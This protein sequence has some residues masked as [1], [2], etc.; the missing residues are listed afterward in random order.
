M[1]YYLRGELALASVNTAV[2]DCGG[3]GY[4]L[5][6]SLNTS[7]ALT[8]KIG[9]EIKLFTYLSVKE[10]GVELFGFQSEQEL[11]VFRMLIGVSGVGP[12]AALAIL[13]LMTPEKILYAICSEDTKALSRASG[14][15]A[16]T[17]AR[18]VLELKD[19]V[20]RDIMNGVAPTD[21]APSAAMKNVAASNSKL[22]EAVDALMVLGYSRSESVDVLRTIDTADLGLEQ[23]ISGALRKLMR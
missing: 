5:T 15:G 17:A 2:V 21:K 12:K 11:E 22:S 19:K 14:V 10:D 7:D 23:I 16:K 13:S 4:K 3:V 1:F 6:V 9:E 18:I 20:S 8:Q